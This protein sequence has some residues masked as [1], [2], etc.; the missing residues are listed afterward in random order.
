MRTPQGMKVTETL[1]KANKTGVEFNAMGVTELIAGIH[2]TGK[3]TF[4]ALGV[5]GWDRRGWEESKSAISV[6]SFVSG[7]NKKETD[8]HEVE[9]SRFSSSILRWRRKLG[10]V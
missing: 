10:Y 9:S 8:T 2:H 6:I 7:G 3:W 5:E 4:N 1:L